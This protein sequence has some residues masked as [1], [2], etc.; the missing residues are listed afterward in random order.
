MLLRRNR[1]V[2]EFLHAVLAQVHVTLD[3][4][5]WMLCLLVNIWAVGFT[6]ST[7]STV[8]NSYAGYA[9]SKVLHPYGRMFSS[10]A[11]FTT[12]DI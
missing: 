3:A 11:P 1:R 6:K 9:L 8:R 12:D 5:W 10:R 2:A 4:I 7:F